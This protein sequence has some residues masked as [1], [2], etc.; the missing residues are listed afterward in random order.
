MDAGTCEILRNSGSIYTITGLTGTWHA[1]CGI[2]GTGLQCTANFGATAFSYA[3]PSGY[4][5][6]LTTQ[7]AGGSAIF[8]TAGTTNWTVPVGVT[9]I[10]VAMVGAGG[11]AGG[12]SYTSGNYGGAGGA[13]GGAY[14]NSISVTPGSVIAIVVGQG[15]AR[16]TGGVDPNSTAG[17]TGT[18]SSYASSVLYSSAGSGGNSAYAGAAGGTGGTGTNGDV[19]YT[20]NAGPNGT[21]SVQAGGTPTVP[22]A[23]NLRASAGNGGSSQYGSSNTA[24]EAGCVRIIWGIGRAFPSTST[25]I[26][27]TEI[28]Y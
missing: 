10:S 3:V 1:G 8:N 18:S 21:T 4:N 5:A 20:G 14:K 28:T 7:A 23:F 11:G 9:S 13:G 26:I 15:G 12:S 22:A 17:S 6:G 2:N 24:G 27:G 25:G 16:G 19:N